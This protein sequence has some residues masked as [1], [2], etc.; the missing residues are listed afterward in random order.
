MPSPSDFRKAFGLGV[1]QVLGGAWRI[2]SSSFGHEVKEQ[3]ER[4]EFP[5]SLEVE[6]TAGSSGGSGGGSK[7]G[8]DRRRRELEAA[9]EQQTREK[10]IVYSAYGSPYECF[11]VKLPKVTPLDDGGSSYQ[12]TALGRAVR[13][14]D[15]PTLKEERAAERT[16]AGGAGEVSNEDERRYL[17]GYRVIKSRF[18]T[19]KCSICGQTI[20]PGVKIAKG[21]GD[22][23]RGG[24]A[25]AICLVQQMKS[26]AGGGSKQGGR[27]KTEEEAAEEA[28]SNSSSSAEE[29]SEAEP[30]PPKRQRKAAGAAAKGGRS[31]SGSGRKGGRGGKAAA[32]AGS[33]RG[34]GSGSKA[35]VGGGAAGQRQRASTRREE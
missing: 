4:Y 31:G 14:R 11:F 23:G 13:R 17:S 8:A 35:K 29:R 7:R 18:G 21:K 5:A 1:E 20:D 34:S 15:I 32:V 22:T 28:G 26:K 25:H 3:N 12:I 16:A 10:R 27:K 24:W 30:P 6:W 33:Q 2:T 9:W 19:S